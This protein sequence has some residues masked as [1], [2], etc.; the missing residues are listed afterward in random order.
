MTEEFLKDIMESSKKDGY[1]KA[2]Y[3]WHDKIINM[4]KWAHD[5]ADMHKDDIDVYI[6]YE[7][8]FDELNTLLDID[9]G[10]IKQA[11]S[12]HRF[13]DGDKYDF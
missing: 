11:I 7:S 8:C 12:K 6:A 1:M 13:L 3:E 10:I 2:R 5:Q 4:M 9:C